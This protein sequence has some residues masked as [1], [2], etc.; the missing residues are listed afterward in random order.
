MRGGERYVHAIRCA[1]IHR[2][3]FDEVIAGSAIGV[4]PSGCFKNNQ[5]HPDRLKPELQPA[6]AAHTAREED[7]AELAELQSR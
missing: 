1:I 6:E 7:E 5:S 4:Q 3:K 2:L